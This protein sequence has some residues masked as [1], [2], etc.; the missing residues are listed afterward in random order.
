MLAKRPFN[1]RPIPSTQFPAAIEA[2]EGRMLMSVGPQ[3]THTTADNR[4]QVIMQFNQYLDANTVNANTVHI[5]TAG[6]SGN[7]ANTDHVQQPVTV[8][9]EQV[10]N[11]IIVTANLPQNTPYEVVVQGSNIENSTD[12]EEV[13]GEFNGA[14]NPSGNG[15]RGGSYRFVTS[16]AGNNKVAVF[17]P[18]IYPSFEVALATKA[19]DNVTITNFLHYANAGLWDGTLIN[20]DVVQGQNGSEFG[21]FQ[22]GEFNVTA[23]NGIGVIQSQGNFTPNKNDFTNTAYTLSMATAGGIAS[24]A[25]FFN[26]VNNP[27][28]DGAESGG[29]YDAFGQVLSTSNPLIQDSFQAIYTATTV[30][31]SGRKF[32]TQNPQLAPA[33][34]EFTNL[35]TQGAAATPGS[36]VR[37]VADTTLTFT[38]VAIEMTIGI[39]QTTQT[40]G[41]TVP[42]V[43]NN[44]QYAAPPAQAGGS[45]PADG[46]D[47]LLGAVSS[48]RLVL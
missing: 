44:L 33:A 17:S 27:F 41:A 1:K 13:D 21:I 48:A 6:V 7:P 26:A 43:A 42:A 16:I 37:D 32:I 34:G 35:P 24:D 4:G 25:F 5:F 39:A 11:Q 23:A 2:L 29:P 10:F 22:A 14:D 46:S 38:R 30:D 19:E 9:Y 12:T 36:V 40:V 31:I 8:S 47:G 3:I 28:L 18:N 45:A 15:K 20:R